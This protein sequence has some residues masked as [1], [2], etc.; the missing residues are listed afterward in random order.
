MKRLALW[1]ATIVAG[2]GLAGLVSVNAADMPKICVVHTLFMDTAPLF[3][4]Q[5][6]GFFK[7]AGVDV[8]TKPIKLNPLIPAALQ[9]DSAQLGFITPPT[10][11]QAIDGGI[12]LVAI[13]GGSVNSATGKSYAVMA[14][15]GTDIKSAKDLVGKKVGV[16]GIGAFL[17]L[18]FRDW[19]IKKGVDPSKI[20]YVEV[21]FPQGADVL[22]GGS[23]DAL[24]TGEPMLGRIVRSKIG[25]V[26]DYYTQVEPDGLPATIVVGTRKWAQA[27]PDAVKGFQK[28]Y[29]E[30]VK[31]VQT[32]VAK[33]KVD[34]KKH[35]PFPPV[36]IDKAVL[37]PYNPK[38]TVDGIK[39]WVAIL[40]RQNALKASIDPSKVIMQ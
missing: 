18:L 20:T 22:K 40:K 12:D 35:L 28:G 9:S 25:A 5:D 38:V 4:G 24:V 17:D 3:V 13:A 11:L 31:V 10:F 33:A 26:V 2:V 15:A 19:L 39:E 8:E 21:P 1:F 14:R 16:P 23:I 30:A 6:R 37:P 32:D 7:N 27:N 36:V 29:A 34:L